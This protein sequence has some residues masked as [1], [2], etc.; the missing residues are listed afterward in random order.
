[1]SDQPD[2]EEEH[3]SLWSHVPDVVAG[4]GDVIVDLAAVFAIAWMAHAGI[5]PSAAQVL[6]GMIVSIAIGKRYYQSKGK[7]S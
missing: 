6:G 7:P 2:E 1:M 5:E 3:R 4:A